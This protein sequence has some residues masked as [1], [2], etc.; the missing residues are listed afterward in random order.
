MNRPIRVDFFGDSTLTTSFLA[1]EKYRSYYVREHDHKQILGAQMEAHGVDLDWRIRNKCPSVSID[2][3]YSLRVVCQ[4]NIQNLQNTVPLVFWKLSENISRGPVFVKCWVRII[5]RDM[6]A[7]KITP[8]A[9][10]LKGSADPSHFI[11]E[12]NIG[13]SRIRH[14]T[15]LKI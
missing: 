7:L 6:W 10:K 4:K 11:F 12:I 2:F 9:E 1:F 15:T 14:V 13:K 8:N 3:I 5:F